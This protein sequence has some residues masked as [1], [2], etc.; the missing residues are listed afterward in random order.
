MA[1]MAQAQVLCHGFA[2]ISP[3]PCHGMKA[4]S[5]HLGWGRLGLACAIHAKAL[6]REEA[7]SCWN[8]KPKRCRGA[9]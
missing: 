6:H 3:W 8:S 4:F 9:M 1:G 2:M 5:S 7:N